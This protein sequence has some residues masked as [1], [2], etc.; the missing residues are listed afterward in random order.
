MRAGRICDS[1][2]FLS[3]DIAERGVAGNGYC[4][5]DHRAGCE[6]R[7][8]VGYCVIDDNGVAA[9]GDRDSRK[10]EGRCG[11]DRGSGLK[12]SVDEVEER[13]E[14]VVKRSDGKLIADR[15]LTEIVGQSEIGEIASARVDERNRIGDNVAEGELSFDAVLV[16]ERVCS[17]SP[18][19]VFEDIEFVP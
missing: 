15:E 4:V 19:T 16:A 18:L 6:R 7:V 3:G 5:C 10:A 13:A 14:H 17:I 1:D 11:Y 8:L 9:R 2:R 12:N